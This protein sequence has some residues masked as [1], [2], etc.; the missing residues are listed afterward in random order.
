LPDRPDVRAFIARHEDG[1]ARELRT[2]DVGIDAARAP[3][4]PPPNRV[5]TYSAIW[6]T[7]ATHTNITS[8]VVRECGLVPTG[9][10]DAIGV[11]GSKLTSTYLIDVYLPS[12]VVARGVEAVEAE[13]LPGPDSVVGCS[14][15]R[16]ETLESNCHT[17]S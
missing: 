2:E 1:L 10:A 4:E 17:T 9:V 15:S 16:R 6:D 11:H 12:L 8:K 14:P 13:S 7:G 5:R 3:D